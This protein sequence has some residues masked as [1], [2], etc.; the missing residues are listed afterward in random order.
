MHTRLNCARFLAV[1]ILSLSF[2]TS[3]QQQV[4]ITASGFL[5]QVRTIEVNES[6]LWLNFDE[7]S[8]HTTTS[9]K[10]PGDPDHW[11]VS[12]NYFEFYTRV[13]PRAG[14]FTYRDTISGF[15]GT[16]IVIGPPQAQQPRLESDFVA[17][18][19]CVFRATSLTAGKTNFLHGSTNLVNWT[20]LQTNIAAGTVMSFTNVATAGRQFYRL[21]EIR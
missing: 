11:N 13:F 3:A 9:D 14:T 5:P 19:K 16:I 20:A 2:S 8:A 12:L 1:L 4:T 15:T 21:V 17:D 18:G 10:S 7:A 6:I